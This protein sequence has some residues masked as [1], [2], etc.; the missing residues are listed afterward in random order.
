MKNHSKNINR[1]F[2][3]MLDY[4]IVEASVMINVLMSDD[5]DD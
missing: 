2:N 5:D 4:S 3:D 1:E